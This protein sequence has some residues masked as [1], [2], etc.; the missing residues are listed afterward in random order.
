MVGSPLI[1]PIAKRVPLKRSHHGDT[2]ID[3]Y[4]WLAD[5]DDPDMIAYVAA[6]N[7]YSRARAADEER[8]R[9]AIYNEIRART[10]EADLSVPI[11][12]DSYWY[13]SRTSA[14]RQHEIRCRC[15]ASPDEQMPL[16]EEGKPPADEEIL[17]DCDAEAGASESFELG[18]LDVSKDGRFLA[19]STDLSGGERFS[20]RVKDLRTGQVLPDKIDGISYGSA[21]SADASRLF[22][23]TVDD[24]GRPFR[25]WRHVLGTPADHDKLILEEPDEHFW[26]GV[27]LTR[28]GAFITVDVRS[29]LTS[30]VW[31][32]SAT[33]PELPP[34]LVAPRCDGIDYSIEHD[35]RRSRLLILH[36]K[37]S[38]DFA[39]AW[40]PDTAPGSWHEL[41]APAPGVRMLAVVAFAD[42]VVASIRR[43]GLT[44]LQVLPAGETYG[45][46][47]EV[48]FPE[49]VHTVSLDVNLEYYA[50]AI[51][52]RYV[53]LVTPESV[54]DYDL[55]TRH[56]TLR[57]QAPV[58]GDYDSARYEQH[59]EWALASDGTQIPISIACRRGVP[60]D[61]TAPAV[62]HGYGAYEACLDP[63]FSVSRLS[64]LD[65]GFVY[66]VAHV[67][68]GGEMGRRWY[69]EGRSLAKKNT[70]TDFATCAH[71][72]ADT[73]WTSPRRLVA[74]GSSAGGLIMGVLANIAP[75]TVAGIV[76]QMPFVDPLT[77]LLD[78]A[79]PLTITEWD[80]W[81]DPLHSAEAYAYIKS[82]SPYENVTPQRY[83][84][85]LAL[86]GLNDIR[87]A[88]SECLKWIARLRSVAPDGEYLLRAEAGTGHAGRSGRY[89]SWRE[90]A[91][92]L[93]W[94][95]RLVCARTTRKA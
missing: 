1:P 21:W 55:V 70:F 48:S 2:V 53:S 51:R 69:A 86:T 67:R 88:P 3:D 16:I 30:E 23:V 94:I 52:I 57:K 75:E 17:L 37:E 91:F 63:R 19:Y 65:R 8:L 25:V 29:A 43:N 39:L 92:I 54:Y 60:R 12:K 78:P 35:A 87:V 9:D 58:L 61:G 18:T 22:Y 68:G 24:A 14:G 5:S 47:Y 36:N 38:E 81:G 15:P 85:V 89:D 49:P 13:Y 79:R 90:E 74:R 31:L 7:A 84:A 28:S 34:V 45:T 11:L 62:I 64:L 93:A 56:L 32:I 20:L 83:P 26:V 4:A 6:E 95:V 40:T 50:A 72:L 71:H 80:E 66:A 41:I 42:A 73:G 27:A 82:Y 44:A 76:T 33:L 46:P 77:S 59:R 10:R